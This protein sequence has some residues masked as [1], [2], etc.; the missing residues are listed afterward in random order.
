MTRG[1]YD[2][3]L[4]AAFNALVAPSGA[5]CSAV[6]LASS[7]R[8]QL[9][10]GLLASMMLAIPVWELNGGVVTRALSPMYLSRGDNLVN[11]SSD[12]NNIQLYSHMTLDGYRRAHWSPGVGLW[13]IDNF[14]YRSLGVDTLEFS[15]AE[16]ADV[17]KAG[18]EVAK[19]IRQTYCSGVNHFAPWVACKP[20]RCVNTANAMVTTVTNRDAGRVSVSSS[21][22]VNVVEG[23]RDSSGGV[24]PRVC[25]WGNLGKKVRCFV[26]D[27]SFAEGFYHS[28][29]L[30]GTIYVESEGSYNPFTPLAAP[31][32]SF[33]DDI[34]YPAKKTKFA[35]WPKVWPSSGLVW[36]KV[37]V[38]GSGETPKTII[39][40][41]KADRN[42][43]FNSLNGNGEER[44][45]P[46]HGL[47][48]GNKEKG[49][50]FEVRLEAEIV[51]V[52]GRALKVNNSANNFGLGS[53]GDGPEGWFDNFVNGRDLQVYNCVGDIDGTLIESCW[54]STNG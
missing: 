51:E 45:I 23:L 29:A 5:P 18:Y 32:I 1:V 38:A 28:V 21:V 17:T 44:I 9:T 40:A 47:S 16:R 11:R 20:N 7:G 4:A 50:V 43:R 34:T 27:L 15:H 52:H 49:A 8:E 31:F 22:K 41:A 13:Q 2:A 35:V 25:R 42:V 37:T 24:K 54:V 48:I 6:Q 10:V 33:T 30:S 53:D 12:S 39:R 26:Y 3:V 14:R 46:F 19:Y 36:P